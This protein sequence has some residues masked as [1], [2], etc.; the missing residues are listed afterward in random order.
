MRDMVADGASGLL[1]PPGDSRGL[2]SALMG[3]LADDKLRA[4][5]GA[6]GKER[7][8]H[9]TASVV[10]EQLEQ[11]YARVASPF[12]RIE[13]VTAASEGSA[14]DSRAHLAGGMP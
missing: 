13:G 1:V 7:V 3:V 11:V 5:L 6:G 14:S 12:Q 2:A 4:R 10:V 8:Q 9:F